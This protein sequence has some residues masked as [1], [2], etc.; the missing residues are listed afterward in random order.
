MFE[1]CEFKNVLILKNNF[2]LVDYL[3]LLDLGYIIIVR[4]VSSL[5]KDNL[6]NTTKQTNEN[7]L[8]K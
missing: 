5:E 1:V 2:D 7:V 3:F 6:L 4:I 8:H